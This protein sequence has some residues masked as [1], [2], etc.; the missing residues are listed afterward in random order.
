MPG[1]ASALAAEGSYDIGLIDA[2]TESVL[3]QTELEIRAPIRAR[4]AWPIAPRLWMVPRE[5]WMPD[6]CGEDG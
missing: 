1:L 5:S 4:I 3:L 6:V 2:Q